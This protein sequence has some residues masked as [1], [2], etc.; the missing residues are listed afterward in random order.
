M[1]IVKIFHGPGE[2]W[3]LNAWIFAYS[4]H[5]VYLII[6]SCHKPRK[7]FNTKI[8]YTKIFHTKVSQTMV[9]LVMFTYILVMTYFKGAAQA[10]LC[11]RAPPTMQNVYWVQYTMC[12]IAKVPNVAVSRRLKYSEGPK[13]RCLCQDI[14]LVVSIVLRSSDGLCVAKNTSWHLLR[15]NFHTFRYLQPVRKWLNVTGYLLWPNLL[16]TQKMIF[17][18]NYAMRNHGHI[19]NCMHYNLVTI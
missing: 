12:N 17:R 10:F 9:K 3:K 6:V 16:F 8:L 2:P 1:F 5:F 15:E 18:E 14:F 4:I 7:Y 19:Q 13:L 11:I